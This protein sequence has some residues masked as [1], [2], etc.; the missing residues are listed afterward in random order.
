MARMTEWH[1]GFFMSRSGRRRSQSTLELLK[2]PAMRAAIAQ[3]AVAAHNALPERVKDGY[4]VSHRSDG[5]RARS[6][7][8]AVGFVARRHEAKH[9]ALVRALRS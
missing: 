6:T 4:R 8:A 5:K 2:S 9:N 3:K 7:V 1:P